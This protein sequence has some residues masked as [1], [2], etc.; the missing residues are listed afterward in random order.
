MGWTVT[1]PA[2]TPDSAVLQMTLLLQTYS[3]VFSVAW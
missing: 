3:V 2:S 1:I